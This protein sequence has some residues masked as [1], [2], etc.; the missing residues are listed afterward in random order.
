MMYTI[1]HNLKCALPRQLPSFAQCVPSPTLSTVSGC[2]TY[3]LVLDHPTHMYF[4]DLVHTHVN[5][6]ERMVD[7]AGDDPAVLVVSQV[8]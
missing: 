7:G 8:S 1:P 5:V 6:S 2:S 3:V 4:V